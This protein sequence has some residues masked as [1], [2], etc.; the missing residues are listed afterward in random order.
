M[1]KGLAIAG[2]VIML[3]SGIVIAVS[4]LNIVAHEPTDEHIVHDT[5]LEGYTFHYDGT[6][7]M[8]EIYAKGVVDC[9]SFEITI[10][11][12]STSYFTRACDVGFDNE[13]YTYLGDLELEETGDYAISSSGDVIVLNAD[14]LLVPILSMCGAPICCLIGLIMLIIGLVVGRKSPP[15][16]VVFQQPGVP[17]SHTTQTVQ[18]QY[19]APTMQVEEVSESNQTAEF[20]PYS[21]EHKDRA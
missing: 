5:E 10:T 15:Q 2:G 16:V 18:H 6:Y 21:F 17:I 12:N 11:K 1:N 4:F 8:I 20:E 7:T 3:I 9:N 19:Q 14:S 13:E